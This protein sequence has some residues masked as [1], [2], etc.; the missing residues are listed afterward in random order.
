MC[1]KYAVIFVVTVVI[2]LALLFAI[3]FVAGTINDGRQLYG[4]D[5][6]PEATTFRPRYIGRAIVY[7]FVICAAGFTISL[8]GDAV[9][10]RR[11]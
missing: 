7:V 11:L 5:D 8:I 1:A 2:A 9:T 10:G 3:M 6:D 4:S